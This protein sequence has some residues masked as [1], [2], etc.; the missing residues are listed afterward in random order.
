MIT[1]RWMATELTKTVCTQGPRAHF[2]ARVQDFNLVL[3]HRLR[4]QILAWV[5]LKKGCVDIST[6]RVQYLGTGSGQ[7]V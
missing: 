4:V 5:C 1:K 3:G 7:Q 6:R 2:R